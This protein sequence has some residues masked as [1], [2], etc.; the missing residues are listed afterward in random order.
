MTALNDGRIAISTAKL[1]NTPARSNS[2]TSVTIP[3]PQAVNIMDTSSGTI[4]VSLD[5]HRDVVPCIRELPNGD[6]LTAGGRFD[7]TTQI[8]GKVSIGVIAKKR[9]MTV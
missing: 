5:G 6:L 1:E 8:C 9:M 2:A 3:S 7:A 4:A